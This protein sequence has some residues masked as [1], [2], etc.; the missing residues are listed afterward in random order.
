MYIFSFQDL[1]YLQVHGA[2]MGP[3][4]SL[5]ACKLYMGDFERHALESAMHPPHWWKRYVDD[6]HTHTQIT[7]EGSCTGVHRPPEQHR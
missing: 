5:I 4:V 6:T 7:F 1:Y 2:A 3:L